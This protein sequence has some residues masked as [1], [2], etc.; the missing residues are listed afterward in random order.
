MAA[1]SLQNNMRPS[2]RPERLRPR[3]GLGVQAFG[4]A[5][6]KICENLTYYAQD[7]SDV[8]I[9]ANNTSCREGGTP[10]CLDTLL[11][12]VTPVRDGEEGFHEW[13]EHS[14]F[15]GFLSEQL[16]GP[17]LVL[18]GSSFNHGSLLI[19]SILVPME[20]LEKVKPEDM[21]RWDSPYESWSCGLVTGGR[22]TVRT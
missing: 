18:Y 2:W 17:S 21:T 14:S 13:S 15:F 8:S 16:Q 11:Q 20:D 19:K 3:F 5:T 10:M 12:I 4:T 22:R 7:G 1:P 9:D 6:L